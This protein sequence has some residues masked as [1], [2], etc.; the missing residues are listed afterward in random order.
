MKAI[1]LVFAGGGFGS[2]LRYLLGRWIGAWNQ[3]PAGTLIINIVA[4]LVLGVVVGLADQKQILS[5]ATRLFLVV[6]FC[7]GFSTFSTFSYETLQLLQGGLSTQAM[8][9]ILLS[10]VLCLVATF[11][12]LYLGQ[13]SSP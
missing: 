9:Y 4:C 11:G 2:I 8:L 7:G 1:L 6:G 12:G 5:P 3:F 13:H 10:I